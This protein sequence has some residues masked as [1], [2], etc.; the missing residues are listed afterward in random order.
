MFYV[1]VG[2]RR[3]WVEM[4]ERERERGERERERE[5]ERE[6]D[7]QTDRQRQTHT[8]THTDIQRGRDETWSRLLREN[9]T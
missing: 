9:S 3:T 6:T 4:R 8:Q 7:R 5:R 1:L 2:L